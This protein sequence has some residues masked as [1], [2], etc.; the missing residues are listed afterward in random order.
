MA[1]INLVHRKDSEAV[2]LNTWYDGPTLVDYLGEWLLSSSNHL[3]RISIDELEPPTRDITAPLRFPISNVFKGQSSGTAVVGCVC[4]GLV[5]VGERLRVLP[6]DETAIVK[7][8]RIIGVQGYILTLLL[9]IEAETESLPWAAAGSSV[10]LY[11]IAIDPVHLNIGSVLC[12][13]SDVVPL[14]RSFSARII[15]FDIQV[16]ITSGASVS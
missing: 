10:T 5:Q 9:G 11:L 15:V 6:G 12:P 13:P 16:P 3:P 14:A 7:S 2:A 1:G 4:S 8:K